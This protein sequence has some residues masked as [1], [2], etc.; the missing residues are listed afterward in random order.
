MEGGV[1]IAV[2]LVYWQLEDSGEV[3]TLCYIFLGGWLGGEDERDIQEG[4]DTWMP[5]ANSR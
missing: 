1:T 3:F 4:G 5:M 2:N